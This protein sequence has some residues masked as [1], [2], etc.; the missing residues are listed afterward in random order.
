MAEPTLFDAFEELIAKA[1]H[2]Q[3]T[4]PTEGKVT[5]NPARTSAQAARRVMPRTGTQRARVLAYIV[6]SGDATDFEIARDVELSSNSVRPRRGE[7]IE[8]GFLEDS[9]KTRQHQGSKWTVWRPTADGHA[10]YR[11]HIGGAA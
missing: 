6:E 1:R 9:G 11:R 8:G 7:L 5:R 4:E 2:A 10:W 3:V